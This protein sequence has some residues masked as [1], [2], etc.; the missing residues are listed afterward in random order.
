MRVLLLAAIVIGLIAPTASATPIRDASGGLVQPFTT[1]TLTMHLPPP[2]VTATVY[3]DDPLC[4]AACAQPPDRMY[5]LTSNSINMQRDTFTHELGHLFDYQR[6]DGPARF[7][8]R[9]LVG[10]MRPWRSDFNSPHEKFAEAYMQCALLGFKPTKI[11]EGWNWGYGYWP[12]AKYHP[13][14]CALILRV[15][16]RT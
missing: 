8:F 12:L 7:A 11:P 6:M 3:L 4:D 15:T 10:D 1:W 5:F 9:K 14:V 2:N 13:K 16:N